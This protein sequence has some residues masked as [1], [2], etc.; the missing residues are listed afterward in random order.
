M[1]TAEA[2]QGKFYRPQ[3]IRYKMPEHRGMEEKFF[4][5]CVRATN[6]AQMRL[7]WGWV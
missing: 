1:Q 3:A 7:V 2:W 5:A 6:Q 4:S